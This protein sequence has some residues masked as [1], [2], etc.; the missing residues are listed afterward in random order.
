MADNI[1]EVL[2]KKGGGSGMDSSGSGYG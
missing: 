1:E 2:Q